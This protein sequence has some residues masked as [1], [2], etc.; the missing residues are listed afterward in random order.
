[1]QAEI[2]KRVEIIFGPDYCSLMEEKTVFDEIQEALGCRPGRGYTAVSKA[3]GGKITP[4]AVQKWKQIPPEHCI[5][6]EEKTGI[7]RYRQRPD[8]FGPEPKNG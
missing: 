6:L 3:L 5:A 4:Q 8:V 1:M 7:S 2:S